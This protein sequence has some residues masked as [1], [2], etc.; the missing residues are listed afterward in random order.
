MAKDFQA[1]IY[2]WGDWQGG[3]KIPPWGIDGDLLIT[4]GLWFCIYK[5]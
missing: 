1:S 2:K 5:Y 3:R 4:N